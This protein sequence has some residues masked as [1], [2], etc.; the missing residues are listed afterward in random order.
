M[1]RRF[2]D[3]RPIFGFK[4][5]RCTRIILSGVEIMHMLRKGQAL[6][7]KNLSSARQFKSLAA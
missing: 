3:A 6:G 4:D 2:A 7:G 1:R 5:F